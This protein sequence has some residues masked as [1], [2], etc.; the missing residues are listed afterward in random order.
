MEL[1]PSDD[2]LRYKVASDF[3]K[4]DMIAEAVAVIRPVAFVLPHRKPESERKRKERER[5][6]ERS[7][8]AGEQHHETAREMLER[9]EKKLPAP[10][11]AAPAH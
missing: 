8:S 5:Q 3:E 2:E 7:R 10:A 9:L 4:R 11:T 1:A 6:E